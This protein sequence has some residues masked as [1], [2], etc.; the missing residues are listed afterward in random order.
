MDRDL[1]YVGIIA[2]ASL[3]AF[4]LFH[5]N[6]D[7]A[8]QIDH[9]NNIIAEKEDTIRYKTNNEGKLVAEKLAA[10]ATAKEIAKAYPNIEEEIKR[11][12][13]VKLGDMKAYIKN[14]FAA[15]GK[16][17]STINN[18]YYT[19][20]AGNEFKRR[21]LLF[22]DGYL[23]FTASIYDSADIASSFYTYSDTIT[24]V[25]H[26]K[27]KWFLGKESL[28][29]SSLLRNPNAKVT[30]TTN[31]LVDTYR[32]KRFVIYVGAGYDP[33]NNQPTISLGV[34]YA[35]IKF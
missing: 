2:V 25:I 34:G 24:T 3:L 9:K 26:S 16:G 20:S 23:R 6:R 18:H 22:Q 31:L 12:F 4:Y 15:N 35:L 11:D 5:R 29:A 28:Y 17:N 19:D 30:G 10:Q 8:E 32:D 14:Q 7:L 21:D 13:D 33:F 1:V 27:K